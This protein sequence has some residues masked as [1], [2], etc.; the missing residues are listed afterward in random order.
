MKV[1]I[2]SRDFVVTDGISNR[3]KSEMEKVKKHLRDG[4]I[5][6]YIKKESEMK[7]IDFIVRIDGVDVVASAKDYD[8]YKAIDMG[9]DKLISSIKKTKDK[10]FDKKNNKGVDVDMK[11]MDYLKRDCVTNKIVRRKHFDMKPM[12]EAEAIEQMELLGHQ[13]F[14]FFNADTDTMSM[15]Y[16]RR[17][18]NYGIID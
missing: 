8:L 3:I 14:M 6:I 11:E 5:N 13:S 1:N 10:R 4:V 2:N 9:A 17:D 16:R 12:T 18:G 15:L 7:L